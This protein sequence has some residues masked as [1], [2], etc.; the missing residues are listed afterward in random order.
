MKDEGNTD[1]P[2]GHGQVKANPGR[3]RLSFLPPGTRICVCS[4]HLIRSAGFRLHQ[5]QKPARPRTDGVAG[6][7]PLSRFRAYPA[8][9]T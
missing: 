3:L 8:T 2:S 4:L 9:G 5:P 7:F 1:Q 6:G